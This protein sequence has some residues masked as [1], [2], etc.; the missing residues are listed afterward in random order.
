MEW[1]RFKDRMPGLDERVWF[2]EP[3][4][5]GEAIS[6]FLGF[7][8]DMKPCFRSYTGRVIECSLD[9]VWGYNQPERLNPET[10]KGDA[11]V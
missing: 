6:I 3:D 8:L 5:K 4:Q 11:I 10:P 9:T 2:K 1:F 7:N